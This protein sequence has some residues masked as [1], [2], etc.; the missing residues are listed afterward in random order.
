MCRAAD[1]EAAG[2]EASE[3]SQILSGEKS[4]PLSN[5]NQSLSLA[6]SHQKKCTIIEF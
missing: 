1:K 5:L 6:L 4:S 3:I 2:G